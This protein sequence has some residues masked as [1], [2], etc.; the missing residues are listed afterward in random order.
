LRKRQIDVLLIT[1]NLINRINLNLKTSIAGI[2]DQ[3]RELLQ[4]YSWPGNVRELEN[5][6]ERAVNMADMKHEDYLTIKHFPSLLEE[7]Y[8]AIDFADKENINLPEA[9]ENLEKQIII[10]ALAKTAGNK[11][12]TAKILGIHSSALYRKITKYGLE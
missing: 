3:A 10:Q 2:S 9:M 6:L 7:A 4:N 8:S 1:E 5:L 11:V 12:Q